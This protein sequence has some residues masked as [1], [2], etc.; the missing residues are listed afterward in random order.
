MSVKFPTEYTLLN[1]FCKAIKEYKN[2]IDMPGLF[3]PHVLGN[4]DKSIVRYFYCGQDTKKWFSMQELIKYYDR[5]ELDKYIEE[6][7]KWPNNEDIIEYSGNKGNF[8]TFVIKLHIYLKKKYFIKDI[9]NITGRG[10]V[11]IK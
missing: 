9:N 3:L 7:N 10:D 2:K 6:N 1:D 8:W 11:I 5:N 4:Y